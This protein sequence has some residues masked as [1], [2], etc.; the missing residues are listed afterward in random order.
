MGNLGAPASIEGTTKGRGSAMDYEDEHYR[1][2]RRSMNRRR[3][4]QGAVA[5]T[6]VAAAGGYYA[7][8]RD[9]VTEKARAERLPDG[10]PRLPPGQRVVEA[11]RDM[12][13]NAGNPSPSAY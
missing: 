13:G 10:R 5:G 3:F 7:L 2:L 8:S 4:I 12:G 1:E 9:H 11:L 6:V